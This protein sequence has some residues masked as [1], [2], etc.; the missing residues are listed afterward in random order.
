VHNTRDIRRASERRV[1]RDF[2]KGDHRKSEC[3][4]RGPLDG[5]EREQKRSDR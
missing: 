2:G 3:L 4:L 1:Q 5:S